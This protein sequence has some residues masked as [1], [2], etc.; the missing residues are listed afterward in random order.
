[1][2]GYGKKFKIDLL[3]LNYKYFNKKF[4]FSEIQSRNALIFLENKRLIFREFRATKIGPYL[5][6]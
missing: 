4:G 3:Q 5:A 2:V 1:M 6:L